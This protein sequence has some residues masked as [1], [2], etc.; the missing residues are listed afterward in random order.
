MMAQSESEVW[1]FHSESNGGTSLVLRR[2][3]AQEETEREVAGA[4][5]P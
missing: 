4:A 5:H 1:G 3:G 2:G